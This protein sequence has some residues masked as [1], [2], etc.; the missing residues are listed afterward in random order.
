M[1]LPSLSQM[2]SSYGLRLFGWILLTS[3]VFTLAGAAPDGG[4]VSF[5]VWPQLTFPVSTLSGAGR[6]LFIFTL[7]D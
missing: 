3:N 7:F 2:R 5:G 4:H 1:G 6:G